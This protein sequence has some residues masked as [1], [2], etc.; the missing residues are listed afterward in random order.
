MDGETEP[1]MAPPYRRGAGK[2]PIGVI[3]VL[4]R[5]GVRGVIG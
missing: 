1:G 2:K 3:N 4:Q 5:Y